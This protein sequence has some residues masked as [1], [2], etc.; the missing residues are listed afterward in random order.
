V[1]SCVQTVYRDGI[2]FNR[3]ENLKLCICNGDWSKLLIQFLKDSP[4][5][6][7][8]NLLV[9]DVSFFVDYFVV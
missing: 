1:L 5:L 9:D 2:V 6:R 8:L 3:L 4:N 7:V